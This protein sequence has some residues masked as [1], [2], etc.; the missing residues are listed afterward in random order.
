[1][2]E[3]FPGRLIGSDP[4][5][6]VAVIKVNSPRRL[7]VIQCGNANLVQV[8]NWVLAAGNPFALGNSFTLGIMR[9]AG[10]DIGDGPFDHFPQRDAPIYPGNSGGPAFDISGAVL[11]INTAIVS[12]SGGSVG[13]GFAIPSNAAR[14]IVMDIIAHGGGS[15]G[16]LGMA[17]ADVTG[18][19]GAAEITKS[20][21]ADRPNAPVS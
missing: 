3:R 1:M 20:S 21:P 9:A 5:T 8:G 10:R 2:Q 16:G 6:D 14:R 13:I 19:A 7:P 4:L 17:V 15:R 18:A 12:P 11:G